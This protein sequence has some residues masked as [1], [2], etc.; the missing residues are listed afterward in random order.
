MGT[1]TTPGQPP[2][3][4]LTGPG[5]APSLI[6]SGFL[7]KPGPL[8]WFMRMRWTP[9]PP[10][11]PVWLMCTGR[12]PGPWYGASIRGARARRPGAVWLIDMRWCPGR[13]GISVCSLP[14]VGAR[15]AA[16]KKINPGVFRLPGG[17]TYTILSSCFI[18]VCSSANSRQRPVLSSFNSSLTCC[19][20][21]IRTSKFMTISVSSLMQ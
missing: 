8:V 3:I 7:G 10:S 2:R 14:G 21:L 15:A 20:F 11:R 4:R 16:H 13:R 17:L 6:L 1:R 18:L 9:G 12:T 5:D 19:S